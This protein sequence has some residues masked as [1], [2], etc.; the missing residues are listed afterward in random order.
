MKKYDLLHFEKDSELAQAAA[1]AW[2]VTVRHS[3]PGGKPLCVALSGG[4]IA[5]GLFR[6]VVEMAQATDVSLGNVH[7]FWADERCVP[8]EDPQSNFSLADQWLLRPLAIPR[9]HIHRIPGELLP[10]AAARLANDDIHAHVPHWETGHPVLDRVFLG[11]GED[12]HIASLFPGTQTEPTFNTAVYHPVTAPKPPPRRITLSYGAIILA[13]EV[14]VLAS[15]PGK[16]HALRTSLNMDGGTPLA[17]VLKR[18]AWTTI[19]TD[20]DTSDPH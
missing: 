19:Y 20:I 14:C 9:E 15:G 8:P 2:L 6:S 17:E 7:F 5:K 16:E 11:M 10:E 12:G 1:N 3:L 18:R 4:R 13:R